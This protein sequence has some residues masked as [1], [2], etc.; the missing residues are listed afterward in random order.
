MLHWAIPRV[1]TILTLLESDIL[2][3]VDTPSLLCSGSIISCA[4]HPLLLSLSSSSD[5]LHWILPLPGVD[6]L[7]SIRLWHPTLQHHRYLPSP[8]QTSGLFGLSNC[9]ELFRK[10]R[11]EAVERGR[12]ISYQLLDNFIFGKLSPASPRQSQKFNCLFQPPLKLRHGYLTLPTSWTQVRFNSE[13]NDKRKQN[14]LL[15][16][17][18]SFGPSSFSSSSFSESG[19]GGLSF[20]FSSLYHQGG[21][22]S[23]VF[24]GRPRR[25]LEANCAASEPTFQLF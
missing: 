17:L 6:N 13:A 21:G 23:G 1:C 14:L 9:T 5:T 24:L 8:R 16:L 3:C 20:S 10:A 7:T 12:G 22:D 19:G 25:G 18:F 11:E 2:S 4:T 15:P